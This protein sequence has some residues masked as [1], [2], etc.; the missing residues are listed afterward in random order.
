ME[1]RLSSEQAGELRDLVA[2]ALTELRSEIFHTD[3]VEFREKL[4][5]RERLLLGVQEQ[6]GPGATTPAS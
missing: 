4:R 1:L 3:T 6:L 2:V 5:E